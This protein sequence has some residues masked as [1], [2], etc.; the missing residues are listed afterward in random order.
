MTIQAE[1]AAVLDDLDAV[2]IPATTD[3]AML[4]ALL[5]QARYAALLLPPA[6]VKG[7]YGLESLR[8]DQPVIL[9]ASAPD[10]DALIHLLDALPAAFG[11]L[12]PNEPADW[13]PYDTGDAVLPAYRITSP[14]ITTP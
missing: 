2:G 5:G 9:A 3:P 6:Q 14:R 8:F 11:V 13:Q 4:L 7:G 10:A 1:R 12:L